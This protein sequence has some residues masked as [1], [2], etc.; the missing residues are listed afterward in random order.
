MKTENKNHTF[1]IITREGE[2]V[3]KTIKGMTL[4]QAEKRIQADV[5]IDSRYVDY[6]TP[7]QIDRQMRNISQAIVGV[8]AIVVT[9]ITIILTYMI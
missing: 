2:N 3:F 1:E 8:A 9:L 6:R 7:Y 4:E 5:R